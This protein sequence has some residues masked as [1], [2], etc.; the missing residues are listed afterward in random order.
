MTEKVITETDPNQTSWRLRLG[1]IVFVVGFLSPLLIPIVTASE[2]PTKWKTVISTGLAVGI[3]ELFSVVA[4]AIM[5]KPG[6][7]YI[8]ARFFAFLK[9]HGSPERVSPVR[10]RIDLVM[11]L[12]PVLFGWL[13]PYVPSIIPGYDLQGLM[14]NIIGDAMLISS[15]FVL[16]GD[17]WDKI[18]SLFVYG[19]TTTFPKP[20]LN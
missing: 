1:L 5:G 9:K 15:F 18:R 2:L 17:F 3:P 6:Y 14:V 16:G 12:L 13:A 10:Y 11:F 19:A 4:I 7:N 20:L 8:K